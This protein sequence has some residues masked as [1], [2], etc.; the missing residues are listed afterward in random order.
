MTDILGMTK[1]YLGAKWRLGCEGCRA[2]LHSVVLPKHLLLIRVRGSILLGIVGLV[3][4]VWMG[5]GVGAGGVAGVASE[6]A[7]WGVLSFMLA[8]CNV[9]FLSCCPI[10]KLTSF[11][12]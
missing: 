2:S 10:C 1:R 3:V 11:Y 9:D 7:F 8:K 5:A 4:V 6:H 12:S